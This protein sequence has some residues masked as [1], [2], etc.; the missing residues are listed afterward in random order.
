LPRAEENLGIATKKHCIDF[1]LGE[2]NLEFTNK[3]NTNYQLRQQQLFELPPKALYFVQ[4]RREK[5]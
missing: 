1:S 2:K 3:S 4:T 5:I